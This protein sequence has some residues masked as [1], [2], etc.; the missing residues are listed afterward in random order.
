VEVG[1]PA[2]YIKGPTLDR[3]DDAL[4]PCGK[5]LVNLTTVMFAHTNYTGPFCSNWK[6]DRHM[7][8][9]ML[10]V[11]ARVCGT[12]SRTGGDAL[13]LAT[14][15]PLAQAVLDA[16]PDPAYHARSALLHSSHAAVYQRILA[17]EK[18]ALSTGGGVLDGQWKEWDAFNWT[19]H[20]TP[21]LETY[22]LSE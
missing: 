9:K 18:L 16:N 5:S 10:E 19:T 13:V 15:V 7:A 22:K 14:F 2:P 17:Q 21:L 12:L 6:S 20:L 1:S 8:P 4:V 3:E 11:N